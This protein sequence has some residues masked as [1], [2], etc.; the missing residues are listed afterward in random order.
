MGGRET[1]CRLL[2]Q[3]IKLGEVLI[4]RVTNACAMLPYL[5]QTPHMGYCNLGSTRTV[6]VGDHMVLRTRY[7]VHGTPLPSVGRMADE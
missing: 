1:P 5:V 2:A 6:H 4:S 3:S 7:M